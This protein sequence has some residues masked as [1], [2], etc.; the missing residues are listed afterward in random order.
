MNKQWCPESA[1]ISSQTTQTNTAG[2]RQKREKRT[3]KI[4]A[5]CKER[6][7]KKKPSVRLKTL[8]YSTQQRERDGKQ[9]EKQ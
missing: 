5:K 6:Q 9:E 4:K 1:G 7:R 3:L 2:D 8:H